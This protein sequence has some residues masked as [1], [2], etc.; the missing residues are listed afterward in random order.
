MLLPNIHHMFR[1]RILIK[2]RI[3]D[4]LQRNSHALQRMN[5]FYFLLS[6]IPSRCSFKMGLNDFSLSIWRQQ[7]IDIDVCSHDTENIVINYLSC[8]PS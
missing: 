3:K 6:L 5:L 2:K 1:A 4:Y 7:G 8:N